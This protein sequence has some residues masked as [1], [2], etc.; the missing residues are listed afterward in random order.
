MAMQTRTV[1]ELATKVANDPAL[2]AEMKQDPAGTLARIATPIPDTFVY[3]VVVSSLGLAIL[4]SL[5]GAIALWW[6]GKTT[7]PELLTAIGSA[8]VGALAGLL[9]PSPTQ[10]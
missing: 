9:A 2:E 3:R 10:G 5:L 1:S 6:I 7:I 4:I 8:A